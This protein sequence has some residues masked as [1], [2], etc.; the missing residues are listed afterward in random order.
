MCAKCRPAGSGIGQLLEVIEKI[1]WQLGGEKSRV[2]GRTFIGFLSEK[3][4]S[5]FIFL[6]Q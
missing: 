4:R 1:K 6:E 5:V 2:D 3:F